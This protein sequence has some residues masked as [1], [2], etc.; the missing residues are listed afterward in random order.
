[1]RDEKKNLKA[2]SV[3]NFFLNLFNLSGKVIEVTIN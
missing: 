1:M 3:P 2:F